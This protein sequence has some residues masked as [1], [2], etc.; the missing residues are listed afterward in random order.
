M[1]RQALSTTCWLMLALMLLLGASACVEEI[2]EPP[3]TTERNLHE[4]LLAED[5]E[6]LLPGSW[7]WDH[8]QSEDIE[9]DMSA[10]SI[11]FLGHDAVTGDV[12]ILI[13]EGDDAEQTQ[14]QLQAARVSITNKRAMLHLSESPQVYQIEEINE[15]QLVLREHGTDTTLIYLRPQ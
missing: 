11:L 1:Q 9:V 6:A 10:L 3:L 13:E 5:V 12:A 4:S 8:T 7:I 2:E 14:R 15:E